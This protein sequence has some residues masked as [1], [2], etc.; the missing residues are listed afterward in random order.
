[1]VR[2]A[3]L[4]ALGVTAV[5][6]AAVRGAAAA[7]VVPA[8]VAA[9]AA[10]ARVTLAEVLA[11]T[12]VI[13]HATPHP[14]PSTADPAAGGRRAPSLAE[15]LASYGVIARATPHPSPTVAGPPGATSAGGGAANGGTVTAGCRVVGGAPPRG[16]GGGTHPGPGA[17]L[18]RCYCTRDA[19][20]V[21]VHG[22]PVGCRAVVSPFDD[23]GGAAAGAGDAAPTCRAPGWEPAWRSTAAADRG[24]R[25]TRGGRAGGHWLN[26]GVARVGWGARR[27]GAAARGVRAPTRHGG[28]GSGTGGSACPAAAYG[29]RGGDRDACAGLLPATVLC[30]CGRAAG[31]PGDNR[32]RHG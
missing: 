22:R 9:A 20:P 19:P 13:A 6:T 2:K 4:A 27:S 24:G 10:A 28:S 30:S 7:V 25:C 18:I 16:W 26:N 8:P 5:V 29:R 3:L 21:P 23:G 15:V 31:T 14:S 17:L 32:D 11:A 1:M 12:D